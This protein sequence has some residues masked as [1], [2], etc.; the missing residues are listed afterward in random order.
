MN[1][2]SDNSGI[3]P[4]VGVI[5]LIGI[6]VAIATISGVVLLDIEPPQQNVTAGVQISDTPDGIEVSWNQEGNAEEI[7]IKVGGSTVGRLSSVNDSLV[8]GAPEGLE[9]SAVGVSEE[10][11]K[12]VLNTLKTSRS[13]SSTTVIKSQDTSTSSEVSSSIRVNPVLSDVEV[14]SINSFGIVIDS[15]KTD[16]SG[17]FTVT[18]QEDGEIFIN[19]KGSTD[20]TGSS[21]IS[22]PLY[23]SKKVSTSE[24]KS[25]SEIS[26]DTSSAEIQTM[27][28]EG[29]QI[30]VLFEKDSDGK[31]LVGNPWQAT[32][33]V[34]DT[35]SNGYK[36]IETINL[37]QSGFTQTEPTSE[38]NEKL[39]KNNFSIISSSQELS[40]TWLD[41]GFGESV[42][43]ES[44]NGE[45]MLVD[46]GDYRDDGSKVISALKSRDISTVDHLVSTHMD[47]DHIGG[48]AEIINSSDIT[49]ESVYDSGETATTNVYTDYIDA[50]D[51]KE[52]LSIETVSTDDTIPFEGA[53]ITVLNPSSTTSSSN[54]NSIVLNVQHEGRS[55]MLTGDIESEAESDII[56]QSSSSML[57]S[58]M[59]HVPHSGSS[60]SST[61]DFITEVDPKYAVITSDLNNQ[62]GHPE[63]SV[64]D[65][66]ESN[67]ID[68]YWT[69]L[70][71]DVTL[72][73]N[74]K[75]SNV[76][77]EKGSVNDVT[78]SPSFDVTIDNAPT[79]ISEGGTVSVE[80]TITNSGERLDKQDI[81]LSANGETKDEKSDIELDTGSS[82]TGT[83]E[84]DTSGI[85]GEFVVTLETD[86]DSIDKTVQIGTTSNTNLLSNPS[87]ETGDGSDA[88]AW[89]ETTTASSGRTGTKA[90]EGSYSI[91][92]NDL[93]SS[94]GGRTLTSD[95]ISV[96]PEKSYNIKGKYNLENNGSG[97]TASNY[98]FGARIVWYDST[99]T[100]IDTDSNFADFSEFN[101]WNSISF[102]ETAPTNAAKAQVKIE[103]KEGENNDLDVYWDSVELIG[104]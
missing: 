21:S 26:F 82:T 28:Y 100:E 29:S 58:Y 103:A 33:A 71:G 74:S 78:K 80:Y 73:S 23:T 47:A 14:E 69:A 83:L 34:Q 60:T 17:E 10:G 9:I 54:N 67:D 66:Y 44:E 4:S 59:L 85:T 90:A 64:I 22:N 79:Q 41:I 39:T 77:I 87:F 56:S 52:G 62:F 48:N 20:A 24:V 88:T 1:I 25:S 75:G 86:D 96:E 30:D 6:T 37:N 70:N 84:W 81:T 63:Q 12:S 49:V 94:Y 76:S 104:P 55:Y 3:A 43:I 36:L 27:T 19:V 61:T 31:Y 98:R 42:L 95:K 15:T 92:M 99:G 7:N 51:S 91:V 40:I 97:T 16:S 8:L 46:T 11:D 72:N 50:V 18:A 2:S 68:L 102:S 101:T 5:L 93:T 53:D 13:T 32:A 57:S 45:T 65:S 35:S 38:F 89:T